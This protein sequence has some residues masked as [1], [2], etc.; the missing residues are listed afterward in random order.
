MHLLL[1]DGRDRDA[2]LAAFTAAEHPGPAR[3]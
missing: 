1:A 2:V 3:L